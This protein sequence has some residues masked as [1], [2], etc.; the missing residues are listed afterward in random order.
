[1][2]KTIV[3]VTGLLGGVQVEDP[4]TVQKP[5]D[6]P[7]MFEQNRQTLQV[8]SGI[9][10]KEEDGVI[11]VTKDPVPPTIVEKVVEKEVVK[12]VDKP[13]YIEVPAKTQEKPQEQPKQEVKPVTPEPAAKPVQKDDT[14]GK[15]ITVKATAYTNDPAENGGTYGGKVLTRT[16]A[17]ITNSILV[18]GL[19]VIAVDPNVIPLNSK[20]RVEVPEMG[21]NQTYIAADTGGAIKGNRIDVLVSGSEAADNFGVRQAKVTIL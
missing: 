21:I 19:P 3:I 15:S 9:T 12:Y 5:N 11:K 17:D 14:G 4:A 20:V 1:M 18:N 2:L 13:V 8:E 7:N 16:G 6:I 10:V